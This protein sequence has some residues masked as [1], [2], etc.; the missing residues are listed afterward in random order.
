MTVR[1]ALVFGPGEQRDIGVL[2][3]AVK[4]LPRPA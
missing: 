3:D 1:W 2:H 4:G